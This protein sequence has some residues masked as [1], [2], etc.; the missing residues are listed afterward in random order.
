[1]KKNFISG[2]MAQTTIIIAEQKFYESLDF[3]C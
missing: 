3:L 1:M 2:F